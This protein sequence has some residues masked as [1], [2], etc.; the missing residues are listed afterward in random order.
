MTMPYIFHSVTL[1]FIDRHGVR[2]KVDADIGDTLL[3]VAKDNDIDGVEGF[4]DDSYFYKYLNF[5][6]I[7]G[8]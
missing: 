5:I 4:F 8:T 2:V 7:N 3:D 6:Y 1:T